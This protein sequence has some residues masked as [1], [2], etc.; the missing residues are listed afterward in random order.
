MSATVFRTITPEVLIASKPFSRF[1]FIPIGGRSTFLLL[2]SKDLFIV[3]STP[4][5][6]HTSDAALDFAGDG[7]ESRVS[8]LLTPVSAPLSAF[9]SSRNSEFESSS[10]T[11]LLPVIFDRLQ[12]TGHVGYIKEWK[13]ALPSARLIVPKSA[14]ILDAEHCMFSTPRANATLTSFIF[15]LILSSAIDSV[16]PTLS[17]HVNPY[18]KIQPFSQSKNH[19]LVVFHLPSQTLIEA[20]L[21]FK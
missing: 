10:P 14:E 12:N 16:P 19:D 11:V 5:D 7:W 15:L 3:V 2:P 6:K 21:L 18:I 17:K 20:D 13:Q 9:V 4:L 1:G 8:Y